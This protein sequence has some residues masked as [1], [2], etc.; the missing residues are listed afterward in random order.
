MAITKTGGLLVDCLWNGL[1]SGLEKTAIAK[2]KEFFNFMKPEAQQLIE[3]AGIVPS[4]ERLVK[5]INLG[6]K[7]I[8][9][10]HNFKII[11]TGSIARK[12]ERHKALQSIYVQKQ[13]ERL[14]ELQK[15]HKGEKFDE[16]SDPLYKKYILKDFDHD[17]KLMKL[18][19]L[20][21]ALNAGDTYETHFLK[22]KTISVNPY[23]LRKEFPGKDIS[24]ADAIGARHEAY[25]AALGEP[26]KKYMLAGAKHLREIFSKLKDSDPATLAK[27]KSEF[28]S[29]NQ[30]GRRSLISYIGNKNYA[31][32]AD[33]RVVPSPN[34]L[35]KFRSGKLTYEPNDTQIPTIHRIFGHHADLGVLGKERRLLDITPYSNKDYVLK[36]DLLDFRKY[37][38]EDTIL[39]RFGK[40]HRGSRKAYN[41]KNIKNLLKNDYLPANSDKYNEFPYSKNNYLLQLNSENL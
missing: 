13:K 1:N 28:N 34:I 31:Y 21:I 5:G 19:V 30:Y 41:N 12:I 9:D 16:F 32:L 17:D 18:K 7:H 27:I 26:K 8:A 15:I 35:T 40:W 22:S 6:T 2:W 29:A 37:H 14:K 38:G 20:Q 3:K 25:E 11:N 10:K 4:R 36:N 33:N 24:L 39:N 23:M